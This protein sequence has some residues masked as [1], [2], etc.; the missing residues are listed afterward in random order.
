[1]EFLKEDLQHLFDD[2]GIDKTQYDDVVEFRDPITQYNNASGDLSCAV[3][4]VESSQ[5]EQ[6]LCGDSRVATHIFAGCFLYA[7]NTAILA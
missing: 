5:L 2:K 1:M 3:W 7:S 4:T 6:Q